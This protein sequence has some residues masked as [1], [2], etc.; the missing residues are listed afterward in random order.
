M[1]LKMV[2]HNPKNLIK[3]QS[4][5]QEF[6]QIFLWFFYPTSIHLEKI[7][8]MHLVVLISVLCMSAMVTISFCKVLIFYVVSIHKILKTAY[9]HFVS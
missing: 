5:Y 7:A 6:H 1:K 8:L 9:T 3:V 2:V 4:V